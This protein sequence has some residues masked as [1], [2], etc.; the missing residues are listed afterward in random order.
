LTL[1][2][3]TQDSAREMSYSGSL[4]NQKE[5]TMGLFDDALNALSGGNAAETATP[6][7]LMGAVTTLIEQHGGLSGVVSQLSQGGLGNAVSSWVGSGAN[8]PV[9]GDALNQALG[10]DKLAQLAEKFGIAP[11]T[12]SQGLA[13]LLPG[14]V[15]KLTPNGELPS[16]GLVDEGLALLKGKLF[17]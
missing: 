12:L 13:Q 9:T 14:V 3:G 16:G 8:Q 7:S 10:S 5:T 6:G 2:D 11:D 4:A 17:G 1:D 15:D